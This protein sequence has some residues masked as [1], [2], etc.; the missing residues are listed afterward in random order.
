VPEAQT[1]L[2]AELTAIEYALN[3]IPINLNVK[4]VVD[5][6]TAINDIKK[7]TTK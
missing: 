1:S 6:K 5:N 4:M 2:A 7:N 3:N